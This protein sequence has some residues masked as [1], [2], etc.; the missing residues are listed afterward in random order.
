MARYTKD[1]E[2][3]YAGMWDRWRAGEMPTPFR[4]AVNND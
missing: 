1:I 4:V 2:A 3:A